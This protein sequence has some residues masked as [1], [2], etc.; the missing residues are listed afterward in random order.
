MSRPTKSGL[1]YFPLNVDLNDKIELIEAKFGCAGFATVVKLWQK[2]YSQDGYYCKWTAD[3]AI[4]FSR[5]NS[6]EF[7]LLSNIVNECLK[8][9]V[10]DEKM[11]KKYDILT[12]K[13]IQQRYL[14]AT[15]KRKNIN[16]LKEYCLINDELTQVNDEKTG[17]NSEFMPQS[18][19][20]ESKVNKSKQNQSKENSFVGADTA[21]AEETASPVV[22]KL[23]LNDESTFVINQAKTEHYKQLYPDVDIE[24]ELRKMQGWCESNPTKRKTAKRIER[25]INSWLAKAQDESQ[26]RKDK[27]TNKPEQAY[28]LDAFMKKAIGLKYVPQ[29][30]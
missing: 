4:L 2:I 28:D 15:A 21:D 18:K 6:I 11:F 23:I 9:G 13:G 29:K 3:V 8:Q 19:V 26:S 22:A 5:R 16:I 24:G 7:K 12:S 20:K 30:E 27:V 17:V 10:F 25:F 14:E 1:D